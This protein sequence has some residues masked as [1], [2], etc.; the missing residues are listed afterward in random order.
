MLWRVALWVI[1]WVFKYKIW[2][3]RRRRKI[4]KIRRRRRSRRR[5]NSRGNRVHCNIKTSFIGMRSRRH[6]DV[7]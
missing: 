6:V 1:N 2:N 4:R 5:S 7:F 3:S